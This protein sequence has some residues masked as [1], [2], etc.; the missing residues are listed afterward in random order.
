MTINEMATKYEDATNTFL[1]VV[2]EL[3]TD[4][5][6]VAPEG[7]WTARQVIH[8]QAHADAYCLTRIIQVV[9]EPGTTIR[10][11]SEAALVE[12]NILDYA[13]QPIEPSIALLKALR[14]ETLRIIKSASDAHL[15]LSCQHS[16]MGEITMEAMITR[17]T[18]HPLEHAGQIREIIAKGR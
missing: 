16:S 12:S 2:S 3:P 10:S 6:D 5:L 14:A 4:L 1:A 8:L 13:H 18:D 11:F 9:S 15:A 17:Y 7:E